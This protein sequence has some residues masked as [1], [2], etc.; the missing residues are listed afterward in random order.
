[1][2]A[3]N[4]VMAITW[5]GAV[6]SLSHIQREALHGKNVLHKHKEP[7]DEAYEHEKKGVEKV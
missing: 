2:A 6:G 1:M 3:N 5:Y 7:V 4:V